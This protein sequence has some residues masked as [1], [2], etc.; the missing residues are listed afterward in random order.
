ML[1][2][3]TRVTRLGEGRGFDGVRE[4]ELLALGV[5]KWNNLSIT[6][7]RAIFSKLEEKYGMIIALT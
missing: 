5:F 6:R 7:G 4:F 1:Q 2:V 3:V